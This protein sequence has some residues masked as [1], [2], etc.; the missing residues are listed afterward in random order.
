M[1][2]GLGIFVFLGVGGGPGVFVGLGIF[3]FLGVGDGPGVSDG[4]G[5]FVGGGGGCTRLMSSE[6]THGPPPQ[7]RSTEMC[8]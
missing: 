6:R 2:V 1:L 7:S 8:R 3:V 5:A 4:R